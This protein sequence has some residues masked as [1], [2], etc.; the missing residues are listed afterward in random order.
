[1][2]ER[3]SPVT[4]LSGRL[5]VSVSMSLGP[6]GCFSHPLNGLSG[7]AS[8]TF[9]GCPSLVLLT[10]LLLLILSQRLHAFGVIIS[11]T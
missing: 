2:S 3:P 11:V 10:L 7:I 6:G 5:C 8:K 9:P 1:M 4:Q